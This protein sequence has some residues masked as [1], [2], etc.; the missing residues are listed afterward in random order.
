MDALETF[1]IQIDNID[2]D[3]V[4]LLEE[5]FRICLSIGQYKKENGLEVLNEAR[6]KQVIEKNLSLLQNHTFKPN[7]E[8]V[9]ITIMAESR[10]L[11]NKL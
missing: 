1:R 4:K 10:K 5:R 11:Q 9:L 7:I 6:E 2:K 3:L 8:E